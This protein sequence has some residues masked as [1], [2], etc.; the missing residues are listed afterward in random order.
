[1]EGERLRMDRKDLEWER[2][3]RDGRGG[4]KSGRD[5]VSLRPMG[6]TLEV[7]R[8]RA[9]PGFLIF[10]TQAQPFLSLLYR[11]E[12]PAALQDLHLSWTVTPFKTLYP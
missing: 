11:G 12:G 6:F 10:W 8:Y 7:A 3:D 9:P 2:R 1:M 5:G 4:A